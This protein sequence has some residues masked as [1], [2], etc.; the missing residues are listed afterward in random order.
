MKIYDIISQIKKITTGKRT[1]IGIKEDGMKKK[2]F[3]NN[4][5]PMCKYC[6][7]GKA[8]GG[9]KIECEKFGMV[10][11][12]DSCKKFIYSPLKRVPK[13]DILIAHSDVNNIE[14]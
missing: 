11:T 6:E 1:F 10:K 8:V 5:K 13:K 12:Y 4:I 9:D 7:K 2:L 14:F 3:G